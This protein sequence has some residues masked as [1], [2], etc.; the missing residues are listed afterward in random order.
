MMNKDFP[1]DFLWGAASAAIQIEGAYNEDGKGLS[2]WDIAD[3]KRIKNGDTCHVACDHY[4]LYKDDVALMKE[5]GLKSYRFSI[6]WPRIVPEKGKI[7]EQGIKFYV[8]LVNELEA[9]GIE[10]LVTL[11]HWDTPVWVQKEG[12]WKSSKVIQYF[13][14]YT[15][16]VVDALSDKVKWWMTLNEPQCYIMN[17]YMQGVHAP[18]KR[19][20]L[21]LNKLTLNAM[22]AHAKAVKI[23]RQ[24]AKIT[25]K[26]GIAMASGAFVPNDE[27]NEAIE[28][29][30]HKTF[31]EGIGLLG[32]GWWMDPILAGKPVKAYGIYHTSKKHLKE[33]QQP[34][35][36]VG[37]N[38]YQPFN[39][40]PWG[41]DPNQKLVGGPKSS[42]GWTIDERVLYWT[43][44]FVYDRYK[45]PVLVS[46]NG[47]ADNDVIC[48]DGKVH[49]PQ[50]SDFIHRYLGQ[51]K[52]AINE[53]VP[54]IGFQYWTIMDNF[55]WAEGYEPRFGL[56]YVDFNTKRR[57]LK[58]SAHEYSKIIETNGKTIN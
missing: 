44:R 33:I 17:G 43:L 32:N 19:D 39:N 10:P 35:D 42:L 11:F 20:Y 21:G 45:L 26:I 53:E 54:V 15:K 25:P 47:V 8:D 16:I 50:R 40:A 52:R 9:A 1:K 58:D 12:G 38:V 22:L 3:K 18:F 14:E 4:H 5:M 51:V 29:A 13:E 36:F 7:N 30:R 23:I 57:V 48:L 28:I 31:N 2:I 34:L 46:E 6:S 49:D 27:S 41:G 56:I 37:V 24:F 55:E